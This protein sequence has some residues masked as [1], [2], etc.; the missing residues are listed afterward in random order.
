MNATTQ[1][2]PNAIPNVS[3]W[4][5]VGPI[6]TLLILSPVIGEVM[7]GATRLSYLFVL[8]PEIMVWGCGT[9]LIRELL[10]HWH[11]GW[12]STLLLGFG[13]AIAEEFLIQQTSIAPLPWLGGAPGYGRV[14]GINWPYFVFMLGYE[15]VWIVL[16]P[17]QVTELFFPGRR[18]ECWLGLR[19][20]LISSVIFVLGSFMAWFLWTQ[21]ARPNVF[22]VPVYHPPLVTI[23]AGAA[24]ILL[25]VVTA[26]LV[27]RDRRT[28]RAEILPQP[29]VVAITAYLLGL[30][31]YGLM[32]LVFGP[33]RELQLLIPILAAVVWAAGLFFLIRKWALSSGWQDSHRWALCFGALLVCMT[34]GFLGASTFSRLDLLGKIILNVLGIAGMVLL[35]ARIATRSASLKSPGN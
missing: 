35:A 25:L 29:W 31:W 11:A 13:L 22:H 16:V 8:V 34:G 30:P 6:L 2:S 28:F 20:R 18:A 7:S 10:R 3:P 21:Q 32:V 27:R 15:A 17:I 4:Q 1:S 9:L 19:G 12:T 14:W 5:K 23:L 26:Y 33:V 24:T